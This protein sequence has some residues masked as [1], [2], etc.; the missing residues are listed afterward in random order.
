MDLLFGN[1]NGL[2]AHV[3]LEDLGDQ[4][5]AVGLKIV[6]EE[7]DEHTRGGDDGVVQRVGQLGLTVLILRADAQAAGLGV[8]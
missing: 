3:G 4:H 8:C 2:A 7:G 5:A 6:L 1:E